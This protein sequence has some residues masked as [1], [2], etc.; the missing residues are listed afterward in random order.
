MSNQSRTDKTSLRMIIRS[1]IGGMIITGV[2]GV[3][4]LHAAPVG[5]EVVGGT[6]SINQSGSN[7][8]INQ[9]SQNMAINWSGYNLNS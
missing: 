5:G 1:I 6:G 7:T 8:T 3:S 9:T 4:E 2:A